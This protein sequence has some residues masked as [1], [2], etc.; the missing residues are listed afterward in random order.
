[1]YLTRSWVAAAVAAVPAL[2][3]AQQPLR[4]RRDRDRAPTRARRG[5]F[6]RQQKYK[7]LASSVPLAKGTEMLLLRAEAALNS[8]DGPGAQHVPRRA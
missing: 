8:G 5:I 1:M 4:G 7:T 3:A 2:A 6:F